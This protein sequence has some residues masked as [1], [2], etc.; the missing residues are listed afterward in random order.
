MNLQTPEGPVIVPDSVRTL[1]N[2]RQWRRQF[3]DDQNQLCELIA[4]VRWDD[5]CKNGHNTL[6]LT[7]TLREQCNG[8]W[9][10]TQGGCLHELIAKV[11][12][13]LAFALPYHLVSADGPLHYFANTQYLAGEKDCWGGLRG[14][15]RRSKKTGKLVWQLPKS[16]FTV[17]H[18]DTEP[19]PVN[20]I[21]FT[22][23][24]GEGKERELD[25]A[26]RSACW[27]E[28][29]DELLCAPEPE[30]GAA[31]AQ[32]LPALMQSFKE[33]VERLGFV[34]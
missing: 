25:A 19:E 32:R 17:A 34:Y 10:E 29:S 16:P 28:A 20:G 9:K 14:V 30:L 6:S 1:D 23:L 27:P 5:N 22:A 8:I 21:A 33:V 2:Q 11:F 15:Q 7:A 24:L 26:R 31:L 13:E 3:R 18:S 4:T 12:P